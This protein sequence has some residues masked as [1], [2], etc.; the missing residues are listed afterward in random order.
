MKRCSRPFLLRIVVM[1]GG[2]LLLVSERPGAVPFPPQSGLGWKHYDL[3]RALGLMPL[4]SAA[5]LGAAVGTHHSSV[6]RRLGHLAERG[7]LGYFS[8]GSTKERVNRW[9][10]SPEGADFLPLRDRFWHADWTLAHL[11]DALPF[12][13]QFYPIA[14]EQ[15]ELMGPLVRFRWFRGISWDAAARYENGWVAFFWSGIMQGE[16][17]LHD[18]FNRFPTDLMQYCMFDE[19][20]FPS[21]LC[22]VVGDSWQRELVFRVAGIYGL[23]DRL[24]VHCLY[25][26]SISG[27]REWHVKAGAGSDRCLRAAAWAIRRLSGVLRGL[28]GSGEMGS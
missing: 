8:L 23:A 18:T 6:Y 12:V 28:R 5:D 14:V 26:G 11:A 20:A 16:A 3:L 27:V 10:I 13:E 4:S 9:Y 17:K 1:V 25:D 24:Q 15:Q 21:L 22:F 2:I 19:R 7:Y